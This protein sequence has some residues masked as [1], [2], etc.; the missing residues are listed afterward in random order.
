M[1][2]QS[3][4]VENFRKIFDYEN[5]KGVYLEGEFFPKV[6]KITRK[7]K[8]CIKRIKEHEKRKPFLSGE[9]FERQKEALN[10]EKQ[11]LKD[12]KEILLSKELSIISRDVVK[13]NFQINLGKTTNPKGDVVY[14]TGNDPQSY[15]VIKQIQ[16]NI[17]KL[18]KV[19]QSNRHEIICQLKNVLNDIFPKY[20]IRTDIENFYESISQAKLLKKIY[21]EPLLTFSSKKFIKQTLECY[22]SLS[23][24]ING[25]P[26]GVGISAYL[27]EL[28]LKDFDNI[29]KNHDE[30]IF[31]ARY[32]DDI[33]VVFS[34]KPNTQASVFL[35]LITGETKKLDLSLNK[36]K[37]QEVDWNI[38]RNSF[39][40]EYLGY[41]MSFFD[42]KIHLS[43]SDKKTDK[44]KKR[45]K[46]S[47]EAY[48]KS[49]KLNEKKARRLLIKRIRFL[50]SNTR[51]RNNKNN[52]LIGIYYSNSSLSGVESLRPLDDCLETQIN[53]ISSDTL[54]RSLRKFSFQKGFLNKYYINFKLSD[55][56]KVTS[57]W[58]YEA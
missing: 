4:T 24:Q 46:R 8:D 39:I 50:T 38:D 41:K 45:I 26:R 11:L 28:Y 21:E 20:I 1:L 2:D 44:Y 37:T 17:K 48:K 57:L 30:V 22:K 18:Y 5:R 7:I 56:T 51:L 31:Y 58:Q 33:V 16:Y 42:G 40:L 47:F 3:F 53:S 14:Q 25:V 54:K 49:A 10:Q 32:V 36:T 35:D 29:I 43:L 15:F 34:P 12:K 23:G 52:I 13:G 55:L 9:V 19:K 27:A 6:E